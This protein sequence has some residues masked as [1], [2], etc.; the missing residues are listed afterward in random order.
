MPCEDNIGDL[1]VGGELL[2]DVL[3]DGWHQGLRTA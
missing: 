1:G 3:R 2:E